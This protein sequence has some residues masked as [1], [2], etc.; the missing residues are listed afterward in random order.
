MNTRSK[1]IATRKSQIHLS[2]TFNRSRT[3]GHFKVMIKVSHI[4]DKV[5]SQDVNL[6]VL[7]LVVMETRS[8]NHK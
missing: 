3:Q 5:L 8:I 1:Y 4:T 6:F 7:F 2:L